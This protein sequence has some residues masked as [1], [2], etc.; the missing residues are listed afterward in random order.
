MI[1]EARLE[2]KTRF[3]VALAMAKGAPRGTTLMTVYDTVALYVRL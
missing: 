1:L 2:F 3:V